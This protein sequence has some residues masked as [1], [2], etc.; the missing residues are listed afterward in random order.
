M[1]NDYLIGL[2]K[3]NNIFIYVLILNIMRQWKNKMKENCLIIKA[4]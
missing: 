3:Y 1:D 2:F 4:M